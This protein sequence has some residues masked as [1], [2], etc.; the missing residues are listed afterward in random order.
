MI[1]AI[2]GYSSTGKSSISKEIAKI[3]NIVHLDTGALY[4][5][6][7][8]FA[9]QNKLLANDFESLDEHLL[10]VKI[11][12]KLID[13]EAEVFLNGQNIA[14]EIRK[15][16]ISAIVSQIA[17]RPKVRAFLLATQ[18]SLAQMHSLIVDGRDIGTVIFPQADFKFFMTASIEERTK[19]RYK[20]ILAKNP[21][22]DFE[23]IK[24]NLLERDKTDE[25][26]SIAPLKQAK[27]ALVIDNTNMTKQE[28]IAKIISVIKNKLK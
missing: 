9:I 19:R 13:H 21:N 8:Y 5:A 2:D 12:L 7:A 27:D 18:R 4:R 26:R 24:Q 15:P 28:S 10:E 25:N 11:E 3:L 1:I 17:S 22:L 14:Q 16:Q 20:E 6:I 23:S